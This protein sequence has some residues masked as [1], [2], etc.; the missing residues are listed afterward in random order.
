MHDVTDKHIESLLEGIDNAATVT[1]LSFAIG[2]GLGYL[3]CSRRE[4]IIDERE[5]IIF[6]NMLKGAR[7][8]HPIMQ[9]PSF[10]RRQAI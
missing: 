4:G 6:S 2:F 1:E 5:Y 3:Q 10:L 8:A 9:V 7:E